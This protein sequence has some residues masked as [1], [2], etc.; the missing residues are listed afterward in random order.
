MA[1]KLDTVVTDPRL[2]RWRQVRMSISKVMNSLRTLRS[3]VVLY[4][5]KDIYQ[6]GHRMEGAMECL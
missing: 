4:F 2:E 1:L 3:C 6:V 5:N